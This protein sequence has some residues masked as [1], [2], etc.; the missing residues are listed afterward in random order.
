MHAYKMQPNVNRENPQLW[1]PL[2]VHQVHGAFIYYVQTTS[3]L[4]LSLYV[5]RFGRFWKSFVHHTYK[6]RFSLITNRTSPIEGKN[7]STQGVVHSIGSVRLVWLCVLF[8]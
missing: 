1:I 2:I 4:K 3:G 5:V 7:Q 6:V 8:F